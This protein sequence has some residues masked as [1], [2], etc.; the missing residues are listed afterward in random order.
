MFFS[1]TLNKSLFLGEKSELA[2]QQNHCFWRFFLRGVVLRPSLKF[3]PYDSRFHW[4]QDIILPVFF[5]I[6]NSESERHS[7]DVR[8]ALSFYLKRPLEFHRDRTVF[9]SFVGPSEEKRA[10]SQTLTQWIVS[11]IRVMLWF[12]WITLPSKY[13]GPLHQNYCFFCS[14]FFMECHWPEI[15]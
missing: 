13:S 1:S 9:I 3:S 14:L 4:S 5:P 7:Q 8:R 6:P 12:G 15:C 2:A 10:S 11:A